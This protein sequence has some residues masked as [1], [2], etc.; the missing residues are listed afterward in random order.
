MRNYDL[1]SSEKILSQIIGEKKEIQI[2][3][4]ENEV[5]EN[6]NLTEISMDLID[7]RGALWEMLD[8]QH[9]VIGQYGPTMCL[10]KV[11][12]KGSPTY[13]LRLEFSWTSKCRKEANNNI[14]YLHFDNLCFSK[15]SSVQGFDLY[16]EKEGKD[17]LIGYMNWTKRS[18]Q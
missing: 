2:I 8:T 17:C 4:I 1:L 16:S 12:G 6:N 10:H 15:H 3:V 11:F 18:A 9:S 7:G 14:N 13:Y 5:D